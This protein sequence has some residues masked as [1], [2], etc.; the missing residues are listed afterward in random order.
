LLR[1]AVGDNAVDAKGTGHV[2]RGFGFASSCWACR[3]A[4]ELHT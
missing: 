1:R 3:R 4:S 2:F